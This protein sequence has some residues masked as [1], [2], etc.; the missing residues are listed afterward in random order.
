[1]RVKYVNVYFTMRGLSRSLMKYTPSIV[2]G[3]KKR[4]LQSV[5]LQ[6]LYCEEL[7]K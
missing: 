2:G 1:L 4:V 7:N 3:K 5:N 6:F